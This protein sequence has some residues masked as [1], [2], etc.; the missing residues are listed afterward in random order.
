MRRYRGGGMASHD[1]E[2]APDDVQPNLRS[3]CEH[4]KVVAVGETGMNHYRLPSGQG[5]SAEDDT[6]WKAKQKRSFASNW[7]WPRNSN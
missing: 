6:R 7:N 5:G 4:P 2:P 3:L 1:L